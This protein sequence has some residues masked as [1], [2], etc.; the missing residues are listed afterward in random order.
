MQCPPLTRRV[1]ILKVYIA[2]KPITMK[3]G[4]EKMLAGESYFL[5]IEY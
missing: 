4:K 3:I 5:M 1:F 2:A